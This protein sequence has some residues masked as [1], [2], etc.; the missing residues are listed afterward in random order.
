MSVVHKSMF[1]PSGCTLKPLTVSHTCFDLSFN[2]ENRVVQTQPAYI[3]AKLNEHKRKSKTTEIYDRCHKNPELRST[4]ETLK[5]F[6]KQHM[7]FSSPRLPPLMDRIMS[8]NTPTWARHPEWFLW[9]EMQLTYG[10]I[11]QWPVSDCTVKIEQK[12]TRQTG[13]QPIA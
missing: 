13:V 8:P 6:S 1:E 3:S 5:L 7:F 4:D 9:D 2:F 11:H 12:Q 10:A